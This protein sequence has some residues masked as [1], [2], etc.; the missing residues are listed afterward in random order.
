MK[1][2]DTCYG[3]MVEIDDIDRQIIHC[4]AVDGRASFSEIAAVL[5][6]SDQTVARRYRR[7]RSSGV[8]R[9]VGLRARQSMRSLGWLLHLRCLPGGAQPLAEGL[10]RRTDTAW[11]Q[12]LSGDTEVLCTVRGAAAERDAVLAK[13]PRGGRIVAV[14]AHQL[15]HVYVAASGG[16]GFLRALSRD[17]VQPLRQPVPDAKLRRDVMPEPGELDLALF[18][19]LGMDGRTSHADLAKAVGWSESTVRRRMD[20]LWEA[21][22]LYYDLELDLPS[23]GFHAPTW[24]WLS[25]PPSELAAIGA[26]FADFPEV[27][28]AAAVTGAFNLLA[29]AVCRDEEQFYDFLTSRV[30]S[31]R[32]VDR[33][34]TSPIIR[35]LKQASPVPV[36]GLLAGL[37]GGRRPVRGRFGRHAEA[38]RRL[39]RRAAQDRLSRPSVRGVSRYWH[40]QDRRRIPGALESGA[41]RV[42]KRWRMLTR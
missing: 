37:R 15:L 13:L 17:E 20:Q 1:I 41:Q 27:A 12:L 38:D 10:A 31:L 16:L 28:Y 35:T 7:M 14:S 5:R 22:M 9:V 33:V 2:F 3:E 18:R 30:G 6:V 32:A 36:V 23:F 34:E 8:F 26:A 42:C 19:E 25:V 24:L 39:R 4:L 29:C 11:V 21:G 40:A